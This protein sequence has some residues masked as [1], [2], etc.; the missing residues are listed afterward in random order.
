MTTYTEEGDLLLRVAGMLPAAE[1]DP[2]LMRV[3]HRLGLRGWVRH[4]GAGVLI[5]AV[6]LEED[7][8][9]LVRVIRDDA[10]PSVNVRGM[11]PDLITEATPGIGERFLVLGQDAEWHGPDPAHPAPLARVA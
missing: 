8:V 7:L 11:D 5:R 10:P 4:D 3:V 9:R 2:F 1:F 6:G